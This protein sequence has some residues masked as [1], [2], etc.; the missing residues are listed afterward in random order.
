SMAQTLDK[1]TSASL[2]PDW[3][4]LNKTTGAITPLLSATT[5]TNFGFDAMRVPFNLALDWQWFGDSRDKQLLSSMSFL[6]DQWK[7]DGTL[8]SVY[9]HDGSIV[10]SAEV[11]ALYGGVIGY[12]QFADT[13]D[14]ANIYQNKLLYLYNPG[15]NEWKQTLSYY[16]D[17]WAW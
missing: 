1:S 8:A 14:A 16:D 10:Q 9:G 12:F 13:S 15:A 7:K 6:G 5:D 11:P 4:S 3:I 17:N 2:P